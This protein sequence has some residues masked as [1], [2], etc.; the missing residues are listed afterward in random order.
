[1]YGT[2]KWD[3]QSRAAVPAASVTAKTQKVQ[4]MSGAVTRVVLNGFPAIQVKT[5]KCVASLSLYGAHLL[6]WQPSGEKEALYMSPSAVYAK[7]KAIRGGVPV[8]WPWFGPIA[9]PQH[10]YARISEWKEEEAKVLDNGDVQVILS[11][12]LDQCDGM[13]GVM[14]FVLGDTMKQTLTTTAGGKP[15][16]LTSALHSYWSVSDIAKVHITGLEDAKFFEKAAAAVPHSEKP[17]KIEGEVDRVYCPTKGDITLV[18]EGFGRKITIT[19]EGS[20]SAIVWN[21]GAEGAK[22][23]A[24]MPD[25]D[26]RRYVCIETGNAPGDEIELQPGQTHSLSYTVA[27]TKA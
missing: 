7:G 27:I 10:G 1:M 11:L 18:D 6:S 5:A 17:L 4:F 22:K 16:K 14:E 20:N 2:N 12:K 15:Y 9:S 8:C 3:S 23:L 21:C 13:K 25:D 19:R 26:Y 24:D